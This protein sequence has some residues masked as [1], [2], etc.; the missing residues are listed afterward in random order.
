MTGTGRAKVVFLQYS[1]YQSYRENGPAGK[2]QVAGDDLGQ[3]SKE[4]G[5][6]LTLCAP[7]R[8]GRCRSWPERCRISMF[9]TRIS[10]V[11]QVTIVRRTMLAPWTPKMRHGPGAP[12]QPFIITIAL[13]SILFEAFLPWTVSGGNWGKSGSLP[14]TAAVGFRHTFVHLCTSLTP[15]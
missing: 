12:G 14:A 10:T 7:R 3:M 6:Y 9:T 4:D 8:F 2:G 13:F 1:R 5:S 15:L 11:P